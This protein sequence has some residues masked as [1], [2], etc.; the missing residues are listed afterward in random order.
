MD[1]GRE[2]GR[3]SDSFPFKK[4]ENTLYTNMKKN[5]LFK[6]KNDC[7]HFLVPVG[8]FNITEIKVMTQEYEKKT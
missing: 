8:P 2:V 3:K 5:N 7:A 1:K 6:N 4:W